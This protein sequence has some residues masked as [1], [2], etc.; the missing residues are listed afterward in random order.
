MKYVYLLPDILT[1]VPNG[2]SPRCKPILI[3]GLLTP[4]IFAASSTLN[5]I[6]HPTLQ[7]KSSCIPQTAIYNACQSSTFRF[8]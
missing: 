4:I 1:A 7:E 5:R 3:Y 2:N 8:A 6:Y